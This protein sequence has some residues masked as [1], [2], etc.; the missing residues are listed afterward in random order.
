MLLKRSLKPSGKLYPRLYEGASG[1]AIVEFALVLPIIFAFM[2]GLFDFLTVYQQRIVLNDAVRTGTRVAATADRY[3]HPPGGIRCDD[4][5]PIALEVTDKILSGR[6]GVIRNK[7]A[8]NIQIGAT[9]EC[10]IE[11]E[12]EA[13]PNCVICHY[14]P[15]LRVKHSSRYRVPPGICT[16]DCQNRP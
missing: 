1:L 16:P 10:V 3:F 12:Y 9:G 5:P 2:V 4:I 13:D 6:G 14:I 7:S 11:V 8:D 15:M